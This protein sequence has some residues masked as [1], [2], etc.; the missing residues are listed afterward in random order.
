MK[1]VKEVEEAYHKDAV[2]SEDGSS[3]SSNECR[4]VTGLVSSFHPRF[5]GSY[6]TGG[7]EGKVGKV[8]Q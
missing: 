2:G 6:T 8:I 7:R 3:R 4:R 1:S 5:S